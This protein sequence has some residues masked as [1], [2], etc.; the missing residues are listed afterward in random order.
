MYTKPVLIVLFSISITFLYT[1]PQ[2]ISSLIGESLYYWKWNVIIMSKCPTVHYPKTVRGRGGQYYCS[3]NIYCDLFGFLNYF[4]ILA[5]F[6]FCIESTIKILYHILF[7]F[8]FYSKYCISL[9]L[10]KLWNTIYC[11]VN[12]LGF[13]ILMSIVLCIGCIQYQM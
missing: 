11:I 4:K 5:W 2:W 12:C 10:G 9:F 1:N 13:Q 6:L 7:V 8:L 3:A